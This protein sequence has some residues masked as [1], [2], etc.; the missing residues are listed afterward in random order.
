[1][2]VSVG[3]FILLLEYKWGMGCRDHGLLASLSPG[4]SGASVVQ[5][6]WCAGF[7]GSMLSQTSEGL[8]G[9]TE[10]WVMC[11]LV[12][13]GVFHLSHFKTSP[14][15]FKMVVVCGGLT[16]WRLLFLDSSLF[17]VPYL[18]ASAFEALTPGDWASLVAAWLLSKWV[19]TKGGILNWPTKRVGRSI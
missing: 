2:G 12:P 15:T 19:F 16:C 7:L 17:S 4:S 9:V 6:E 3:S 5:L 18:P 8:C 14:F 13:L 11:P 10:E 1:M